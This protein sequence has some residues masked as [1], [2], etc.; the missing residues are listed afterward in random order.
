LS[1]FGPF[2]A[3]WAARL[4][5]AFDASGIH[6]VGT[7]GDFASGAWFERQAAVPGVTV[8]RM[9]VPIRRTMVEQA[10]VECGGLRIE[11]LPMFDAPSCDGISGNL[12]AS[13]GTGDIGLAEFPSNAASIKGQPLE[14]L[15]RSTRHRA[16][17][18]ATRVTGDSLAPINAQFYEI[19]F[20]PPVLQVP[21]LQH[22]FLAAQAA[23][24][25][26]V[27]FI[28]RYRRE[29][30]DSFNVEART[31]SGGS[32]PPVAIVTPRTGWWESTAERAGGMLAWLAAMHAAG[33]LK[34]TGQLKRDVVAWAT[35]GHEL[36]H[37]GLHELTRLNMPVV[38]AAKYWLHLG[39]NLGGAGNLAMMVRAADNAAAQAMRD[40]LVEEGYPAQ[41]IQVEPAGK[42][43]GEGHDLAHLGARVLSLAGSNLHFH[44]ASDRWPGNVN[45]AGIAS[46]ARA[47]AR[48]VALQAGAAADK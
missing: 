19:P 42:L 12:C 45:S 32:S 25:A 43:S 28:S 37:L 34:Q 29:E 47:V 1:T 16:L 41:H 20:G 23:T 46:I 11:G 33:R 36:G 21:G 40:L 3:A 39:A 17:V 26:P 14:R 48:W 7:P 38:T 18:V 2:D 10:Y 8:T 13:G 5:E 6:R 30:V 4:T 22:A 15:R 24:H 9:P 44:A 31:A 35:C 27:R